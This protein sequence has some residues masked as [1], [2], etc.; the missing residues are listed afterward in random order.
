MNFLVKTAVLKQGIH[1]GDASGIV[2]DSFRIS[3]MVLDQ[4]ENSRNGLLNDE[5]W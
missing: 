5:R 1:S 4:M 3:R 2:P